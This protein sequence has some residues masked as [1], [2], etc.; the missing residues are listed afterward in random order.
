MS[1]LRKR[2][3]TAGVESPDKDGPP[4][5]TAPTQGAAPPP[6]AETPKLVEAPEAKPAPAEEAAKSAIERRL[7][8][9]ERAQALRAQQ[10][11]ELAVD[12]PSQPQP[13]TVEQ[14]IAGSG[15]PDRAKD[16]LRQ[17][18]DYVT[19]PAKNA[20]V[21]KMHHV[22]EYQTGG[23]TFTEKYFHRME[24]LLGLRPEA[25]QPAPQRGVQSAPARQQ[26]YSG[27]PLS[28]PPTREVPSM[29]SGRP[30]SV[31]RPLTPQEREAARFSGVSEAE[32]ELQLRKMEAL[33]AAGGIQSGQDG[34]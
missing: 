33:K 25:R 12:E 5:M 11:T 10:P 7:E 17:H 30:V 20:H 15:L 8:E 32:Y 1:S 2:Y 6:A 13:V 9:M 31:R 27:P 26:T 3:R 28:A 29:T 34:R 14:I 16:W 18:P 21:Q 24:V 19:D 22:A 23:E 4:V